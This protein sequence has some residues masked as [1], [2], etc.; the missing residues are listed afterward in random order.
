MA[1]LLAKALEEELKNSRGNV[2]C[3]RS[4]RLRKAA[5]RLKRPPVKKR[6]TADDITVWNWWWS[7]GNGWGIVKK[8]LAVARSLLYPE[9][10]TL[11]MGGVLHEDKGI[12]CVERSTAEKIL[13][14]LRGER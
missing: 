8:A 4:T 3:I 12:I 6:R 2:I 5:E 11:M 9:A 14:I 1:D 13:E 10:P 7:G